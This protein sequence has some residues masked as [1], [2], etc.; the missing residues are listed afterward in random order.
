MREK[1]W[2][3]AV[4]KIR[5]TEFRLFQSKNYVAKINLLLWIV[6]LFTLHLVVHSVF[7]EENTL[8]DKKIT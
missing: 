7:F 3:F 8:G 5:R 1:E 4:P 2:F 6:E